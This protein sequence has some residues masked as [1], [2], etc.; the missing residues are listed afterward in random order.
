[1]YKRSNIPA[2]WTTQNR[3][4]LTSK[5][6][7]L[8]QIVLDIFFVRPFRCLHPVV[9]YQTPRP[10]DLS[11]E[12]PAVKLVA[13]DLQLRLKKELERRAE[14]ANNTAHCKFMREDRGS[15]VCH[16]CHVK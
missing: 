16:N 4:T 6:N 2:Q 3:V 15:V 9:P 5:R 12:F 11:E 7:R 10:N 8:T 14:P 13:L 1:M